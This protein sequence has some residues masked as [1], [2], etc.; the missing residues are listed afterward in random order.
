MLGVRFTVAG[1]LMFGWLRMRGHAA[2]T[3]AQWRAATITGGL[4]LL[5]G[6]GLVGVAEQYIA[7]GVAALLVS[8]LPLWMVLL[9]WLWKG[10]PRPHP[11]V[12]AGIA[13]GIAGIAWLFEAPALMTEIGSIP[14]LLVLI[15][16]IS[17]SIASV[18]SPHAGLPRNPFVTSSMQMLC[19]GGLLLL[20]AVV[21]G[22]FS[23]FS[24]QGVSVR[25]AGALAY[26]IVFGSF[27]AFS[28]YI[29][30]LSNASAASVSTY[31]FVNPV[32]AVLLG[33]WLGNEP[34]TGRIA[35]AMALLVASVVLILH[36]GRARSK[37]AGPDRA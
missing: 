9:A 10:G 25:S 18:H 36:F 17:W 26:L 11:V 1:A 32:I 16:C 31:A 23:G 14:G 3:V 24:L 19:G 20:A 15:G 22:E 27:V 30:L 6:T 12:F 29:W 28:A 7:S 37:P 8:T 34:L 2:P 21:F 5:M 33:Y 13:V 35:G 4:M